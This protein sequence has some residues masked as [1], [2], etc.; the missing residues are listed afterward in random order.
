M[1]APVIVVAATPSPLELGIYNYAPSTTPRGKVI[2]SNRYAFH[3]C[4]PNLPPVMTR[5][6]V[7]FRKD[8]PFKDWLPALPQHGPLGAAASGSARYRF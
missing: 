3:S 7:S 1:P 2:Y 6:V 4:R 5:T 8:V